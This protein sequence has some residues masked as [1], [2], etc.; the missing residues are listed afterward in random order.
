[1]SHVNFKNKKINKPIKL[2]QGFSHILRIILEKMVETEI[3]RKNEVSKYT[4]MSVA[5]TLA[6]Y[7]GNAYLPLLQ[8]RYRDRKF[9]PPI[10]DMLLFMSAT[11][12]AEVIRK[13]EISSIVVVQT[14]IERIKEVNP[15]VNA[16]IEER[17]EMALD[18]ARKADEICLE[19]CPEKI[20][21]RF[22]LLGV[23]FTVKEAVGVEGTYITNDKNSI[24]F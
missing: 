6:K 24:C 5:L 15:V 10:E 19:N 3:E 8:R 16:V 9:V 21:E 11:D 1:M 2:Y 23:P 7:V 20:K 13:R 4:K 18:D 17:F 12:L 14:Y 22:P